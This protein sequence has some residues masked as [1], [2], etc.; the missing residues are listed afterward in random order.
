MSM[1]AMIRCIVELVH[2]GYIIDHD[3]RHPPKIPWLRFVPHVAKL[4][5]I[6]LLFFYASFLAILLLTLLV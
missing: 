4:H 6:L 5:V 2:P 1:D 3:V